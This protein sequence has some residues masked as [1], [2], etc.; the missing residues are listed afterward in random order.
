MEPTVKAI[1]ARFNHDQRAARSYCVEMA[2]TYAPLAQEYWELA[3]QV[4]AERTK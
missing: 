3:E 2:R 1:L 4:S